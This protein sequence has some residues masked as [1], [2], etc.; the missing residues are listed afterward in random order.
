TE[1]LSLQQNQVQI[2]EWL[3]V[4]DI[5]LLK[6]VPGVVVPADP[7]LSVY[8]IKLN[9]QRGPTADIHVRRA[10][11]YAMDYKGLL[12]VMSGRAVR[13]YGPLAPTVPGVNKDL[14][15]FDTDLDKAKA[16]LAQSEQ[17]KNGFDIEFTY[18]TGLEEERKTGLILLDQLAKLNIKVTITPV[19]WANA[20]ATFSDVTKSPLMFPIYSSSDFPDPDAFLWPAFHSSSAGTWTGADWYKNTNVDQMLEQ[21][22]STIDPTQRNTLYAQVQ[23]AVVDQSAE[24]F[25]FTQVSGLP[26]RDSLVGYEVCPVMGSSPFWYNISLKS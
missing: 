12:D 13:V 7:G 17:Y 11:A 25:C 10:I 22:R 24:V 14:K 21:A 9:N 26:H 8:T 16:E 18:V 20:V 19:E 6:S 1:R 23:Q 15:G 5:N 3:S 2:A 4:D